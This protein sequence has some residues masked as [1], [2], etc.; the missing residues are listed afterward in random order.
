MWAACAGLFRRMLSNGGL[1]S[2][3]PERYYMRGAGPKCRERPEGVA[4]AKGRR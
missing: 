3:Q 4:D 1:R 2:Y